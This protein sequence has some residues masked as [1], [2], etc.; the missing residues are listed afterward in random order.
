MK[1]QPKQP[2][3]RV[4]ISFKNRDGTISRRAGTIT[5]DSNDDTNKGQK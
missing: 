3:K 2:P 4:S 5:H 1:K